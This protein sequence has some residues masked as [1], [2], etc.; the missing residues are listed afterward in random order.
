[1]EGENTESR[2]VAFAPNGEERTPANRA[3]PGRG[4]A[5]PRPVKSGS[6]RSGAVG[7]IVSP[8]LAVLEKHSRMVSAAFLTLAFSLRGNQL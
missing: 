4:G 5:G 3:L 2:L 6:Q 1:M 7:G 8:G